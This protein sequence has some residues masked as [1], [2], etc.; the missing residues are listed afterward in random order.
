ML[1]LPLPFLRGR[2]RNQ[3]PSTVL[4]KFIPMAQ[5]IRSDCQADC[6]VYTV[7]IQLASDCHSYTV[8]PPH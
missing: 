7:P 4:C 6:H 3:F 2:Y 1:R 5:G 8:L